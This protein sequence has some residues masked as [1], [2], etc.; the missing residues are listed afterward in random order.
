MKKTI[1]TAYLLLIFKFSALSAIVKN[2]DD[3]QFWTGNGTNRAALVIEWNDGKSPA[4]LAWG[5]RWNGQATGLDMLKAIAGTSTT[6]YY[7]D[8]DNF[9]TETASGADSKLSVTLDRFSFGDSLLTITFTDGFVTRTKSGFSTYFWKYFN[10]GGSFDKANPTPGSWVGIPNSYSGS[11]YYPGTSNSPQ[12]SYSWTGAQDRILSNGSWDAWKFGREADTDQITQ[13][14]A[15][16][17]VLAP[18]VN[19]AT[20]N[21]TT[22]TPLSFQIKATNFPI[23]YELASGKLPNGLTLNATTG[24]LSGTPTQTGNFTLGVTAT[25]YAGKSTAKMITLLI[26]LGIPKVSYGSLSIKAGTPLK[27]QILAT[28]SPTKFALA[29]GKLPSGISLNPQ[30]GFLSGTPNTAGTYAITFTASNS[31]GTSSPQSIAL[32]ITPKG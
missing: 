28:N 29:S 32:T 4:S 10:M 11:S 1:I 2:F 5:F 21:G 9:Q 15:R 17:A 16:N 19:S 27:Y 25:N 20:Q 12:F 13:P 8:N 23:K 18:V 24:V 7:D 3:I 30:T 6:T 14:F 31:A 22:G 26:K